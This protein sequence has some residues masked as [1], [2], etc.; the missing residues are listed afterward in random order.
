MQYDPQHKPEAACYRPLKGFMERPCL[1]SV[2][3]EDGKLIATD[4]NILSVIPCSVDKN[5]PP[6]TLIPFEAVKESRKASGKLHPSVVLNG[7]A[8]LL[9]GRTFP[10]DTDSR[11]P[12]WQSVVPESF[13]AFTIGLNVKL[14][15]RLADAIGA[16]VVKI[17]FSH[18]NKA[19]RVTD[20]GGDSDAWG[21]QMPCRLPE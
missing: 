9:D 3:L 15:K 12:K 19:F 20:I 6:T 17:E 5:D 21:I 10:I 4:G 11:F 1:Q 13:T 16:E 8:R 14:L 7:D 18:E 2:L